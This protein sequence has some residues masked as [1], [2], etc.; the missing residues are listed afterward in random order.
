MA[1]RGSPNDSLKDQS[2]PD[3]LK[4]LADELKTFIQQEMQLV[5]AELSSKV[6]QAGMGAG[7][8]GAAGFVAVL[9]VLSM[10]AAAILGLSLVVDAWLAALIVAGIYGFI[11][12]ILALSGKKKVKAATPLSPEQ[13][14]RTAQA[15]KVTV[16]QAWQR[17]AAESKPPQPVPSPSR[18]ETTA[19][20]P[21]S[22]NGSPAPAPSEAGD[23]VEAEPTANPVRTTPFQTNPPRF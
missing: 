16:Q 11:A 18:S 20:L 14:I 1:T 10:T 23:G 2:W 9:A 17:G 22:G 19:T 13:A 5:K 8:F 6:K 3:V 7:M 12:A 21:N 4:T 15:A